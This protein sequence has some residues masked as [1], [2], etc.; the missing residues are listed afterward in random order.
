MLAAALVFSLTGCDQVSDLVEKAKGLVGDD[1]KPG[2]GGDATVDKVNE[3]QAKAVMA[4][5]SRM[6][7]VEFYSD[8]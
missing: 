5:E 6:V 2:A 7:M 4:Q 1:G 3:E 8:T